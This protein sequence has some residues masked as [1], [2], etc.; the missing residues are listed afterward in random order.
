MND[1]R[2]RGF[3]RQG[4]E[5][6][7]AADMSCLLDLKGMIDRLGS[8]TKLIHIAQT[9]SMKGIS[10]IQDDSRLFGAA[11]FGRIDRSNSEPT[12]FSVVGPKRARSLVVPTPV[13]DTFASGK[14]Y[15][16]CL[17]SA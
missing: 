15:N 11:R 14:G 10:R 17:M 16:A 12:N 2:V 7:A 6:I 3:H 8:P 13:M 4:A 5:Y 9:L 1:E